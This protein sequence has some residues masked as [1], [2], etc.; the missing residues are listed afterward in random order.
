MPTQTQ[1]DI[2]VPALMD[3]EKIVVPQFW[4][5]RDVEYKRDRKNNP[6]SAAEYNYEMQLPTLAELRYAFFDRPN[7]YEQS[8]FSKRGCGEWTSTFLQDGKNAIE[9]P[10]NETDSNV[11]S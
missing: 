10:E 2:H 9:R 8:A 5:G 3:G 4:L 7:G 6:L 1:T 11:A